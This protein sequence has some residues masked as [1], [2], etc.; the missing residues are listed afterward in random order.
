MHM[1]NARKFFNREDDETRTLCKVLSFRILYGGSPYAFH[2]DYKMPRLGLKR[3]EEIVEQFYAKY[4]GLKRWQD[5][6]Y[7]LVC[8]QGFLVNPTGRILTFHKHKEK[9]GILNYSKPEVANYCVQSLATADIVPLAM[10]V[11]Y[12]RLQKEELYDVK[13]INQVHD[14]IILDAPKKDVDKACSI[15]IQVFR[16]IPKLVEAYF[17][18]NYNVPMDGDAKYGNNWNEM[19]KW[20]PS[21]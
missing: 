5:N 2:M 1:D 19:V 13:I 11:A 9:G 16:D 12:R 20:K 8:K 7:K 4:S 14:S 3:W 6:N 18:F 10:I 21:N 15:V 17:G